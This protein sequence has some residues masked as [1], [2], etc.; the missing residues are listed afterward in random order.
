MRND[1]NGILVDR[2][3]KSKIGSQKIYSEEKTL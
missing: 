2:T 1:W 3:G